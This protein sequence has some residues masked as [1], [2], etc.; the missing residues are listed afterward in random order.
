[1]YSISQGRHLRG[2]SLES[3][4]LSQYQKLESTI[5]SNHASLQEFKSLLTN[6]DVSVQKYLAW[7]SEAESQIED[8]AL[9]KDPSK[10]L[11]LKAE[12]S[13]KTSELQT[14]QTS[15]DSIMNGMTAI[16]S[17]M[18]RQRGDEMSSRLRA[19]T[20]KVNEVFSSSSKEGERMRGGDERAPVE[21]RQKFLAWIKKK[22]QEIK[23]LS[24]A[25]DLSGL[26]MQIDEHEAF[27]SRVLQEKEANWGGRRKEG[28]VPTE[29][30]EE[31]EESRQWESLQKELSEWRKKLI[32]RRQGLKLFQSD[33]ESLTSRLTAAEETRSALAEDS[34]FLEALEDEDN[35]NASSSSFLGLGDASQLSRLGHAL[36]SLEEGLASLKAQAR[37]FSSRGQE[38]SDNTKKQLRV[39]EERIINLRNQLPTIDDVPIGSTPGTKAKDKPKTNGLPLDQGSDLPPG[40][41][42]GFTEDCIPYFLNHEKAST[43]WD[44]PVFSE[45]L[46]SLKEINAVQYSVYRLS[47]KLRKIQQKLCLDLLDIQAA[48]VGF[49]E[50]GLGS[51]RHDDLIKVPE[52][53][54]VLHSLISA[55]AEENPEEVNVE[56][57]TNLALNWILNV[58]DPGRSGSIRLF[59]FK[60]T[61]LLFSRGPL[62]DKYKAFYSLLLPP[63]EEGGNSLDPSRLGLLIHDCLQ[64]PKVFGEIASFGGS[65]VEPSVRSCFTMGREEPLDYVDE[66][67]FTQWLRREP[68]CLVW[69]PV[70]HR[71]AWAELSKHNAKCNVCKVYPMVGFR[72]LCLK[73]FNFDLCHNCF[74]LGK[75]TKSHSLDHP[76]KEFC[77]STGASV[78]L[79]NFTASLRN[80][81]RTKKYFKKKYKQLC[82]LPVSSVLEGEDFV[83]PHLL[84]SVDSTLEST[85]KSPTTTSPKENDDEEH[86]LISKYCQ[87][88]FENGVH[89]GGEEGGGESAPEKEI[90]DQIKVENRVCKR[91]E[92]R[93]HLLES[94]NKQLEGHVQRLRELFAGDK[95]GTLNSKS[96]TA[97][98]LAQ[99]STDIDSDSGENEEEED[100]E[101][102]NTFRL[103]SPDSLNLSQHETTVISD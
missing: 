25:L 14:L 62:A 94:H 40:W 5:T 32:E 70:L 96:I 102:D 95:S 26:A 97:S 53:T 43:T 71:L 73:C 45:L 67:H 79:K 90:I 75:T 24:P 92:K 4:L 52:M 60:I 55:A 3:S 82:Y 91:L 66:E 88:L 30:D 16:E 89:L 2:H 93:I 80:S 85:H 103:E 37:G 17:G 23:F 65:N 9:R 28:G 13:S 57:C 101:N 78:N 42:R 49:K 100:G 10:L 48:M 61:V 63:T 19:L 72:Y 36:S 38:L 6:Y 8:D 86:V 87:M 56:L 33:F 54:S 34:L 1:M 21:C 99:S 27:E 41:E 46:S 20:H 68:Q 83:I 47:L 29:D 69:L 44:H 31:E 84:S 58:H 15:G 22:R 74:F 51:E 35:N 12:I 50:L 98:D 81:F 11:S 77:T 59:A 18:I 39:L 7:L 76:M 64:V